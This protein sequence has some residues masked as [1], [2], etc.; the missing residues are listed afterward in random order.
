M[1]RD[2][3][4]VNKDDKEAIKWYRMSSEQGHTMAK[5]ELDKLLKK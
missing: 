5:T 2:G 3:L 4:G 1:Y